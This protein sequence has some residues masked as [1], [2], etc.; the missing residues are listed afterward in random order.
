M[1][2]QG[3]TNITASHRHLTAITSALLTPPAMP[4]NADNDDTRG[5]RTAEV[6]GVLAFMM[7][8][9]Y[10]AMAGDYIQNI[11]KGNSGIS[12]AGVVVLS[13]IL[14]MALGGFGGFLIFN[15]NNAQTN[16]KRGRDRDKN[17]VAALKTYTTDMEAFVK[18]QAAEI[19]SLCIQ[20]ATRQEEDPIDN[21]QDDTASVRSAGS[22]RRSGSPVLRKLKEPVRPQMA[23]LSDSFDIR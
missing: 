1:F 7:T 5:T 10:T 21:E 23:E 3:L 15:Y 2:F 12:M 16:A 19:Q 17:T 22:R 4:R 9:A 6:G 20:F 13:V 11:G 18:A 14:L 8:I